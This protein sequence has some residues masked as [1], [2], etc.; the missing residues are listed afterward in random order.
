MRDMIKRASERLQ[1]TV[2][3]GTERF[4]SH[5]NKDE[6]SATTDGDGRIETTSPEFTTNPAT[7]GETPSSEMGRTVPGGTPVETVFV[8]DT[9]RAFRSV[10]GDRANDAFESYLRAA[11]AGSAGLDLRV[12]T[13]ED[14]NGDIIPP[15]L[16]AYPL[17]PNETVMVRTGL[18]IWL[19]DPALAAFI[20]PRSGLGSKHG[21]VLGNLVGLIDADYQGELKVALWN[22]GTKVFYLNY[23]ERIAQ[24]T[25]LPRALCEFNV[26]P[27]F[28]NETERGAGGFGH[29]GM[30]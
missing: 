24:Y 22:R 27:A 12:I 28:S 20:L 6:T 14:E 1:E 10:M 30:A 8:P 19:N 17:Q 29:S 18:A 16:D 11:T 5:F 25:V 4:Q 9:W 13:L 26:V 3:S 7:I 21:I 15:T 23:G 2:T